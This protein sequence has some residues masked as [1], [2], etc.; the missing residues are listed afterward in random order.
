MN[1]D[2]SVQGFAQLPKAPYILAPN[3]SSSFDPALIILALENKDKASELP[4]GRPVFLAK[5]EI[6]QSKRFKGFAQIISTFFIDRENIRE[7]VE[8]IDKMVAFA[9]ENKNAIVVFPEGTRSKDGKLN[10]FKGGAFRAAKKDFLPIVPVT[11]N[12]ALSITDFDRNGKLKV[13]VIFHPSI[14]PINILAM[15]TQAIAKIVQSKVQ[16]KLINPEGKRSA[17]ESELV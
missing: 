12:N 11:I 15:D 5:K 9:K 10:E 13:E 7:S 3:H 17:A 1:I 8:I 14:K 2:L 4:N 16:S 6:E